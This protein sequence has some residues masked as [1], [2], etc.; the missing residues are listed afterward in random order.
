MFYM[1]IL[2]HY[3]NLGLKNFWSLLSEHGRDKN[4]QSINAKL[5]E[6]LKSHEERIVQLSSAE[7]Q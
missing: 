4:A 1:S 7:Q 2:M 5:T 3:L 6:T